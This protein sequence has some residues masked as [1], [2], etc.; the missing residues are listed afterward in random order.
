MIDL[1]NNSALG[2][3]LAH[4][5]TNQKPTGA[6]CHGP[7]ALATASCNTIACFSPMPPNPWMY[8]GY[9][10]T[11]FPTSLDKLKELQWGDTLAFYPHDFLV[12]LGAVWESS[13]LPIS[14]YVHEDREL[15]TGQN[16]FSGDEFASKFVSKLKAYCSA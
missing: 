11:A 4:F 9:E 8:Y 13:I 16:P 7:V 12:G 3:I 6:I 1:W 15:L 5:H 2:N 14:S 10:M